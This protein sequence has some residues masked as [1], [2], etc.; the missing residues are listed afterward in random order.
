MLY[1]DTF[2]AGSG[3]KQKKMPDFPNTVPLPDLASTQAL[4]A[5]LAPHLRVGDVVALTGDLGVGKTEFARAL[6]RALGVS[7]DVPSPTFTLLQ[8]YEINDLL[9]SHFDLYRLKAADELDELGW[10]D[11]LADGVV[12]VE[13]PER[14]DGRMPADRL[15]L[16][17]T[18]TPDGARQCGIEKHGS[19]TSR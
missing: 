19:W 11:A 7:G 13:W 14:A 9:V 10:D 16:H 15:T 1:S 8:T 18:L 4:A 12:L 5:S 3:I 2:G 17:F 6:L